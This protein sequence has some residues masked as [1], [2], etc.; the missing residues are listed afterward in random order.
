MSDP[1]ID[2]V[3]VSFNAREHLR[4]CLTSL[5]DFSPRL[6]SRVVVVDNASSDGRTGDVALAHGA[7]VRREHVPGLDVA[8]NHAVRASSTS[9]TPSGADKSGCF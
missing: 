9:I 8:R 3:I 7:D 2:I 5:R 1:S 6:P 4:A